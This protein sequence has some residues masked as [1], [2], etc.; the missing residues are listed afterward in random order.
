MG[1]VP[2]SLPRSAR[3]R[4]PSLH[5][6][7]LD[8]LVLVLR[9]AFRTDGERHAPRLLGIRCL[10]HGLNQAALVVMARVPRAPPTGVTASRAQACLRLCASAVRFDRDR[11]RSRAGAAAGPKPGRR[12]H[13]GPPACVRWIADFLPDGLFAALAYI[14]CRSPGVGAHHLLRCGDCAVHREGIRE[15]LAAAWSTLIDTWTQAHAG[16]GQIGTA[17]RLATTLG[18][19][20]RARRVAALFTTASRLEFVRLAWDPDLHGNDPFACRGLLLRAMLTQGGGQAHH[21]LEQ[22]AEPPFCITYDKLG[23]VREVVWLLKRAVGTGR[24]AVLMQLRWLVADLDDEDRSVLRACVRSPAS[25]MHTGELRMPG[26]LHATGHLLP[27][28]AE[29]CCWPCWRS[30]GLVDVLA[31]YWK[32][33]ALAVVARA[34]AGHAAI[35]AALA[36]SV[37]G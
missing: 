33:H 27:L 11:D 8:V 2:S 34:D 29:I 3:Y 15:F 7:P 6:L 16:N 23:P 21:R 26:S 1:C 10:C 9:L 5:D 18:Q 22:L 19:L 25:R 36:E 20:Y 30:I 37:A 31:P 17:I 12:L 14:G 13:V 28:L 35:L 24:A 32:Q 4:S